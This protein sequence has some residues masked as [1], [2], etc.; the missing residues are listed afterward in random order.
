MTYAPIALF[1]YNRPWHTRQTVEALQR[2]DLAADGELI[3]YSDG[4]RTESDRKQVEEVRRYLNSITGFRRVTV[5]ERSRNLGLAASVMDG[6]TETVN[7]FGRVVVLEDDLVVSAHF[8]EYMNTA[9]T[10]FQ[11]ATRVM[12][13]S[14]HMFRVDFSEGIADSFF[15]PYTTTVGWGTWRRAWD[16]FDPGMKGVSLLERDRRAR[17]AFDMEGT[18]PYYEMIIDQRTGKIDSWGIQWYLSVF[19]SRGIV[20]HPKHSL[21]RH[22]GFD[23]G[24][25]HAKRDT[26][27]YADTVSDLPV[28]AYPR[29]I[30]TDPHAKEEYVRF[31]RKRRTAFSRLR[32]MM[33]YLPL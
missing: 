20:L 2:N 10:L 23:E 6:V 16:V 26:E 32:N 5:V 7:R 8:L 12:Q 11:D 4:P 13:I 24:A 25:T 31:F 22:I 15:L 9:L 30:G 21:V 14:G 3:I 28:R 29:T 18:Y 1:T 19:S 17:Q 33:K 27:I